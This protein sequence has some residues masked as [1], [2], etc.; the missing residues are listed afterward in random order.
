M[1]LK[2]NLNVVFAKKDNF[3]LDLF[4]MNN[5]TLVKELVKTNN[6]PYAKGGANM[7]NRIATIRK[8]KKM[9]QQELAE[10]V[11]CSYWWLNKI[12]NGKRNPGLSLSIKIADKLNVTLNDIFLK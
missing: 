10:S 9:S 12:E 7:K 3:I 6:S 5:Y 1:Q 8:N 4:K 2:C 11:G